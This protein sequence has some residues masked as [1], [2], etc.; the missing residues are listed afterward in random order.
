MMQSTGE[1]R[2]LNDE[3]DEDAANPQL[4]SVTNAQT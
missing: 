3:E 1:K 4:R 2:L